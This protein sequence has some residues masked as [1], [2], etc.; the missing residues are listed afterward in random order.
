MIRKISFL[1][2]VLVLVLVLS[3]TA[4]CRPPA[5]GYGLTITLSDINLSNTKVVNKTCGLPTGGLSGEYLVALNTYN[6]TSGSLSGTIENTSTND[7]YC[8]LTLSTAND[9][10]TAT[11]EMYISGAAWQL[12]ITSVAVMPGRYAIV[13][14]N[15]NP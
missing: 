13:A 14:H 4:F 2:L 9:V 15:P 11:E 8:N 7:S 6:G 3:Q 1:C 10:V 12:S 5:I